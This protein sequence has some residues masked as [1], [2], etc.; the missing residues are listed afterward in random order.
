MDFKP[1]DDIFATGAECI[2]NPV[3]CV[4][5]MGKGLALAFAKR[6]P[7]IMEPYKRVC[8]SGQLKPGGV[9]LLRVDAKTGAR[10]KEGGILI[11]NLATKDH[12]RDPSQI[13]WVDDGMR[14]LAGALE[15]RGVK[16]VA[17]PKL[18]AGLGGLPW[19]AVRERG[20]ERFAAA[21]ANGMKVI[22]LGEGRETASRDRLK[23]TD[24]PLSAPAWKRPGEKTGAPQVLN[25]SNAKPNSRDRVYI[26]RN[27]AIWR[28][29]GGKGE[30]EWG[31][32]FVIG[33]DGDRDAV[34][35]KY[36]AWLDSKLSDPDYR[37]RFVETL[38]GKDQVCH[39]APQGCHGHV[40]VSRLDAI[41]KGWD[42]SQ[43]P[44]EGAKGRESGV[45]APVA[46]R[47]DANPDLNA[48]IAKAREVVRTR[49]AGEP[50]MTYAGIGARETP[51][52]VLT[53]MTKIGAEMAKRGFTLRSG[54]AP[55]ADTAF[56]QGAVKGSGER[57][58]FL[59]W[60][61]YENR[62]PDGKSVI[63]D[64]SAGADLEAIARVYHGAFD[65]LGRG[66]KALMSRNG[67]QMLGKKLD[68]PTGVVICFTKGGV[69]KGGTGQALRLS[70]DIGV[71]VINLGEA[72]WNGMPAAGVADAAIAIAGG[73][74]VDQAFEKAVA[75]KKRQKQAEA[76]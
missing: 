30:P 13:G 40:N 43:R 36:G 64:R 59:P 57:E 1:D 55:G 26:G 53:R 7:G 4:G 39:C 24:L 49:P 23:Q 27:K 66:G 44:F 34:V 71:G 72:R 45:K 42:P 3:N 16:S 70:K 32:P 19:D 60:V 12:W 41:S 63:Y 22:V 62:Q 73:E 38:A 35:A 37:G 6:Y 74:H 33:K 10:V 75:A 15:T 51:E 48:H 17:I 56:E 65:R 20:E 61:G 68:D 18:G 11:A 58:I 54:A 2:I 9:Q 52:G 14:K 25:V 67:H 46:E 69:V 47:Q 29:F 5:V 31:N 50:V 28:A 76:R 21:S 8:T